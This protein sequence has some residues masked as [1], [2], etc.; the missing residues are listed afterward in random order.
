MLPAKELAVVLGVSRG[1]VSQYVSEG[2]L[3]GCFHGDGRARRFDLVKVA[4][5]LGKKLDAGQML[6]NGA[7]TKRALAT[8]KD[9]A[10]DELPVASASKRH[11]A[12]A[13]QLTPN[14]PDRY[15]LA[16]IVKAEEDARKAQRENRLAE[17]R[18]VLSS[19]VERQ[20]ARAIGQEI[21]EFENVMREG[22]RRVADKLGVDFLVVRQLLTQAWRDHRATRTAAL[23]GNAEGAEL[24]DAEKD[25][26]I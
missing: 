20:V 4:A 24:S 15:E 14:D 18:Y 10:A 2:K 8:L 7:G 16:R 21:G 6:G 5:A 3:S 13:S 1:R 12:G 25:E 9:E 23:Q 22:A 17:G 19:E 11:P 26:D